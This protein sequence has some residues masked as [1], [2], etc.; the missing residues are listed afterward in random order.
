MAKVLSEGKGQRLS[1]TQLKNALGPRSPMLARVEIT[2][3]ND[4]QATLEFENC[5][6]T[7]GDYHM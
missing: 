1:K 5:S 6:G 2:D 7:L 3:I 4:D